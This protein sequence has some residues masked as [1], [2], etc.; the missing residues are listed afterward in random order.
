MKVIIVNVDDADSFSHSR[1]KLI[2]L[3]GDA[4]FRTREDGWSW[5]T[6]TSDH[7]VLIRDQAMTDFVFFRVRVE[8]IEKEEVTVTSSSKKRKFKITLEVQVEEMTEEEA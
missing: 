2:G 1:E 8:P 3:V 6:F 4:D 7:P 5:G